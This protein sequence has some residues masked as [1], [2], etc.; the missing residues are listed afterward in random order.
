MLAH[1]E[2]LLFFTTHSSSN[3]FGNRG[4]IF[5][6]RKTCFPRSGAVQQVWFRQSTLF[7]TIRTPTVGFSNTH[8]SRQANISETK[9][10]QT[11]PFPLEKENMYSFFYILKFLLHMQ[12]NTFSWLTY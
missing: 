10:K 8:T 11:D 2:C 12:R 7:C 9:F 4:L 5:S 6:I 1:M 3:S